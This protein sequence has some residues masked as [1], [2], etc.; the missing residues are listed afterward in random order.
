MADNSMTTRDWENWQK[1]PIEKLRQFMRDDNLWGKNQ[2]IDNPGRQKIREIIQSE[3][4]RLGRKLDVL[5][6]GCGTG[7]EYEGIK[8]SDLEVNYTGVDITPKMVEV[9]AEYFPE[10]TFKV[11]DIFDLDFPD[12]QF[13]LVFSRHVLEH[14]PEYQKPLSELYRVSKR[15]IDRKSVV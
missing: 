3:T 6:V 15:I 9:A 14:L 13:D 8:K 2:G 1:I 11:S 12:R 7:I 4:E 10:A 5:E